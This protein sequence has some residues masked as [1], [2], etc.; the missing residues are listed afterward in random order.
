[1]GIGEIGVQEAST[2]PLFVPSHLRV[3]HVSGIPTLFYGTLYAN[4]IFGVHN[5][6]PLTF[7]SD[8]R[9]GRVLGI[10]RRLGLGDD[11]L[12]LVRSEHVCCWSFLL[13]ETQLRLV[14]LAR[15]LIANPEVLC[16]HHPTD[17]L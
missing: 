12:Q 9:H 5:N 3:L 16:I 2:T 14:S 1:M 6:H 7:H 13:S 10:C 8:S 11:V 17:A 15:A 4:L